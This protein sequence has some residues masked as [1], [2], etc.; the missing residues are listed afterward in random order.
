MELACQLLALGGASAYEFVRKALRLNNPHGHG[1]D[2]SG[3][4]YILPS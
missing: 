4:L 2:T 3:D 1:P